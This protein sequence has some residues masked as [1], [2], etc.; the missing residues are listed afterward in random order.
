MK[1][2]HTFNKKATSLAFIND[3]LFVSS[4]YGISNAYIWNVEN[5]I[6]PTHTISLDYKDNYVGGH[7]IQAKQFF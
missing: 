6:E 5:K 1:C 3:N 4:A 2:L 7:P